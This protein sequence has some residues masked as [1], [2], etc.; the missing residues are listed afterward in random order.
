MG[1]GCGLVIKHLPSMCKDCGWA[2]AQPGKKKKVVSSS[3]PIKWTTLKEVNLQMCFCNFGT[4]GICLLAVNDSFALRA[5]GVVW[6]GGALTT[7][8][9]RLPGFQTLGTLCSFSFPLIWR[10]NLDT[11]RKVTSFIWI[12]HSFVKHIK[13]FLEKQSLKSWVLVKYS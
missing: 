7:G 2:L 11:E 5:Q 4:L 6:S 10:R 3:S 12:L 9:S 8:S 13:L 1:W